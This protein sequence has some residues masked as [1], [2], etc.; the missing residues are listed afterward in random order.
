MIVRFN[1]SSKLMLGFQSTKFSSLLVSGQRLFG[2]SFGN[3]WNVISDLHFVISL[4]FVASS[5]M[6]FS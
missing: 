4:I 6:V 3:G 1:P 5:S 2:S